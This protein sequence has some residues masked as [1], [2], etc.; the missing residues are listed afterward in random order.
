MAKKDYPVNEAIAVTFKAKGATT[1]L[2]VQMDV[3]D[4]TD[5][6]DATKS[7][8]MTENGTTGVYR[9]TFT[10]DAQGEWAVHIYESGK[11]EEKVVK[12]Y[13]VGGYSMDGI[14]TVVDEIKATVDTLSDPPSIA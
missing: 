10:P 9:A 8:T 6:L 2:T 13:S 11:P 1:G 4:E 14:G 7:T 12:Q 5:T 3:Y